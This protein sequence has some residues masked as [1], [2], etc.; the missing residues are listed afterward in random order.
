MRFELAVYSPDA[1][2]A[3]NPGCVSVDWTSMTAPGREAREAA[4]GEASWIDIVM[5]GGEPVE[6]TLGK[7]LVSSFDLY[8]A[9]HDDLLIMSDRFAHV[10]QAL[11]PAM[12]GSSDELLVD[13]LLHRAV[14]GDETYC[15]AI[16]R[17]GHGAR[18]RIDLRTG[19]IVRTQ[20]ERLR[21]APSPG[22]VEDYVDR[23]DA[24]L[25]ASAAAAPAGSQDALFLSG[26]V[27]STLMATYYPEAEL[28][29]CK[30]TSP[31]YARETGYAETA[32][33]CLG[34][35]LRQTVLPEEA[36]LQAL[37][38]ATD[39]TGRPPEFAATVLITRGLG[40][41]HERYLNA[42]YADTL[43]GF[44]D[45]Y[46]LLIAP[47]LAALPWPVRA[48]VR[49]I[50]A[51]GGSDGVRA[52]LR[53]AVATAPSFSATVGSLEGFAATHCGGAASL[54][55]AERVFGADLVRDRLRR[56]L[57]YVDGLGA[58]RRPESRSRL[59]HIEAAHMLSY[60]CID[61]LP[62]WRQLSESYGKATLCPFRDRRVADAAFSIP[63]TDRYM[64]G[65]NLKYLL[66]RLLARK[67][68]AYPVMQTKLGGVLP[69][70]RY[71]ASG[72]LAGI[73]ER[74]RMPDF[75]HKTDLA[76]A[77]SRNRSFLWHAIS[78]AVWR[79]RVVCE[80]GTR[81]VAPRFVERGCAADLRQ[82]G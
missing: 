74:Y 44:G 62:V 63:E 4:A 35:P 71:L 3:V 49:R 79:D 13:H 38:E 45:Y 10:V 69:I 81:P 5:A 12:R 54:A 67:A 43:L 72:S 61:V 14:A 36:Y 21:I 26:G 27:D 64:Q 60:F 31:E 76:G 65:R 29:H 80:R 7:S 2:R 52:R 18:L 51:T 6:V 77:A 20:A 48:A 55:E 57:D 56:R 11:P 32:A 70:A 16:R 53:R 58:L 46:G 42:L 30:V 73:A 24:A 22:S 15:D 28:L 37:E 40:S 19:V 59:D 33:R 17:I 39:R 78:F 9:I 82:T 75:L 41:D 66:K 8:Y 68:P 1:R 34:R 25:S 47:V 23:I 50:A